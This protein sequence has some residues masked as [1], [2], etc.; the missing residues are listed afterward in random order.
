M[1]NLTLAIGLWALTVLSVIASLKITEKPLNT[2]FGVLCIPLGIAAFGFS[3]DAFSDIKGQMQN[4]EYNEQNIA[5][6]REKLDAVSAADRTR[7]D[8]L[9]GIVAAH[10]KGTA[11]PLVADPAEAGSDYASVLA[12]VKQDASRFSKLPSSDKNDEVTLVDNVLYLDCTSDTV[13]VYNVVLLG[14]KYAGN[15]AD[16]FRTDTERIDWVLALTPDQLTTDSQWYEESKGD[17]YNNFYLPQ[18]YLDKF[19]ALM[20]N[21]RYLAMVHLEYALKPQLGDAKN[22]YTR[23][24]ESGYGRS[25]VDI[26]DLDSGLVKETFS[27]FFTNN[28]D[29]K[30]FTDYKK[31]G[32]EADKAFLWKNLM[33]CM[34]ASVV[35]ELVSRGYQHKTVNARD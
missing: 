8:H 32:K 17:A 10:V 15:F 19:V 1:S 25:R 3:Y 33:S 26:Y 27:V 24:F 14:D 22:F 30:H 29:L 9:K 23:Y 4:R 18:E 28:A 7:Y 12:K 5:K 13:K 11:Q 6:L 34:K 20:Q 31:A 2:L 21:Y 35:R 16:Y